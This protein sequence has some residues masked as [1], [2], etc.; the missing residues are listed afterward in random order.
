[1]TRM[2]ESISR[3]KQ[4]EMTDI[5]NIIRIVRWCLL[6]AI[7]NVPDRERSKAMSY[8]IKVS[9]VQEITTVIS[10]ALLKAIKG[11]MIKNLAQIRNRNRNLRS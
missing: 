8:L 4:Q 3:F 2:M 7:A 10:T 6:K 9:K 11:D 1:M 5:A